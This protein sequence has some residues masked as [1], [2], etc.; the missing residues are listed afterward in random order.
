M[1]SLTVFE[2][3]VDA[4]RMSAG[5]LIVIEGID[6]SGKST[7][8]RGLAERLRALGRH[9]IETREPTDGPDGQK[10][11]TLAAS[12]QRDQISAEEEFA[13]FHRD[14]TEHVKSLIRP[15]LAAGHVVIQDRSYFSTMAYQGQRGIPLKEIRQRSE[16]VVTPA[17][18]A[19]DRGYRGR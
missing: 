7:L 5:L 16:E 17:R 19:A 18:L 1:T 12:G 3:A 4:P 2:L 15:S 8:A 10:I 13:L 14:R 6:G 9:V 11:R